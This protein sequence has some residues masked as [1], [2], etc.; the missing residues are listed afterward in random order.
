MNNTVFG[1]TMKN[2]RKQRNVK[3]VITERRRNYWVPEPNYHITK[4][5][6]EKSKIIQNY[7]GNLDYDFQYQN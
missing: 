7:A 1:K 5:F 6:T 4:F 3:L 2:V